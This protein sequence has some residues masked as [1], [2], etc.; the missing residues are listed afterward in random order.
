MGL[1]EDAA[2]LHSQA[3]TAQHEANNAMRNVQ[4]YQNTNG[5]NRANAERE[6]AEQKANEAAKFR[7][8]ATDI[9]GKRQAL[10]DELATLENERASK[11]T[12][13][14]ALQQQAGDLSRDIDQLNN[15]IRNKRSELG[16]GGLASFI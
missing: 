13:A 16:G 8:Q 15:A 4:T 10:S 14:D 7:A 2:R 6:K 1:T 11:Q 9:D 3:D 5:D 12:R